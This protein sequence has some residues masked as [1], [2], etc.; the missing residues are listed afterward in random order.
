MAWASAQL[1]LLLLSLAAA[2]GGDPAAAARSSSRRSASRCARPGF[3]VAGR[4]RRHRRRAQ[5]WLAFALA[6]DLRRRWLAGSTPS[7]GQRVPEPDGDPALGRCAGDGAAGRRADVVAGRSWAPRSYH[8]LKTEMVR[9]TDYWRAAARRRRSSLL[10]LV[11]PHGHRRGVSR[12]ASEARRVMTR[13]RSARP[14][15]SLRRRP[16]GQRRRL[17]VAAGRVAG[18]DRSQRRRQDHLLQHAE[19]PDAPGCRRGQAGR[20]QHFAGCAAPRSGGWAS[21]GLSRS[22]RPSAR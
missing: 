16:C 17:S 18:A 21:A 15:E 22:P 6:G 19:R 9:H 8:T 10:V 5:Q 11:F 13:A 12:A 2:A 20:D 4:S 3:A 7:Q 14:D 1:G